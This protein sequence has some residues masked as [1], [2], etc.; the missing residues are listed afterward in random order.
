MKAVSS[1][2]FRVDT[3]RI[4]VVLVDSTSA[5]HKH[6]CSSSPNKRIV[7]ASERLQNGSGGWSSAM[8]SASSSSDSE[9]S[10]GAEAE[11]GEGHARMDGSK[12][13]IIF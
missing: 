4:E 6:P 1:E 8:S 5:I 7:P 12:H 9:G 10:D 3:C 2:G 13:D 11:E